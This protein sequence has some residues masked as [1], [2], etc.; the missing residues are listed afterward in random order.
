MTQKD[1]HVASNDDFAVFKKMAEENGKKVLS[2]AV[3]IAIIVFGYI[4]ITQSAKKKNAEA[5][6]L[7]SVAINVSGF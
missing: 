6:E 3:V 4:Y 7:L 2:F 1:K 5:S